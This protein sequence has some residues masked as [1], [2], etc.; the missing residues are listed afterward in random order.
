MSVKDFLKSRTNREGYV[1]ESDPD[2]VGLDFNIMRQDYEQGVQRGE[3]T[4]IAAMDQNLSWMRG[5]QNC[6]TGWP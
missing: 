2:I 1:K 4:G 6:W 3:T 5:H